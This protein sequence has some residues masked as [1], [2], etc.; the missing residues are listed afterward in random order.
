MSLLPEV[1]MT[2]HRP[3]PPRVSGF[4][5]PFWDALAVGRLITTRCMA[6][7]TLSFPPRNLC[8]ACWGRSLKWIDLSP[9]GRLYSFTRVHVVPGAFS[10]DAPYAIGIVD[11]ADGV[12]LM[13]RMIG[14]VGTA[15]LDGPIEMAV[16][17]YE[18]GPL[19]GARIVREPERDAC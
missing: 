17:R 11:L 7:R 13:C 14:E 3:F 9:R 6:C 10:H 4:T 12:R 2:G 16:L 5:R 19:F 15:D 1:A 8:R 18:D